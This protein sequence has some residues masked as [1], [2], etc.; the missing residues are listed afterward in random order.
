MRHFERFI[1]WVLFSVGFAL[2]PIMFKGATSVFG[3]TTRLAM[4]NPNPQA[5][6]A[7]SIVH[8]GPAAKFIVA[9]CG[10]GELLILAT[11][12]CAGAIGEMISMK[13]ESLRM[14]RTTIA[15]LATLIGTF[16]AFCYA[17]IATV[18]GLGRADVVALASLALLGGSLMVSSSG[19]LLASFDRETDE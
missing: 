7:E 6:S 1:R 16:C 13:S 8:N 4:G 17:A 11:S 19:V 14:F 18:G 5:A 10:E 3:F 15:G 2:L 9:A 12:L